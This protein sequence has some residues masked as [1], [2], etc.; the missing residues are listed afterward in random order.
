LLD[1]P[2][3]STWRIEASVHQVLR[4]YRALRTVIAQ[5]TEQQAAL[6]HLTLSVGE[7]FELTDRL[8][9]AIDVLL[10]TTRSLRREQASR[11][12]HRTSS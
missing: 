8:D 7:L 3:L 5:F 1:R 12:L 10:K 9:A 6:L 2:Q 4:E 11:R